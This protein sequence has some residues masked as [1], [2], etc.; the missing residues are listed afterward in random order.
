MGCKAEV[1][2]TASIQ[3]EEC[4]F[5]KNSFLF[6]IIK[7]TENDIQTETLALGTMTGD[8]CDADCSVTNV[9]WQPATDNSYIEGCLTV[10]CREMPT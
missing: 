4:E 7:K 6:C 3:H 1:M 2:S 5:V 8:G 9:K 10:Q